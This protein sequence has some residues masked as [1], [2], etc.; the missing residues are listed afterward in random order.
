MLTMVVGQ[1]DEVVPADAIAAAIDACRTALGDRRPQ[2]GIV[3]SAFDSFD[4]SVP[5]ALREAF[6]D[7]IVMG[8]TSAAEISSVGGYQEDSLTL[9][10][11]ASDDVDVTAGLAAA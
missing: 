1:S 4:A 2:A 3:F 5:A 7:A 6:P 9:A 8:S 10:M 11:F